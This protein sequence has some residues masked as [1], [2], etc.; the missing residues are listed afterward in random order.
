[1]RCS[2]LIHRNKYEFYPSPSFSICVSNPG[3]CSTF[4]QKIQ[5]EARIVCL[6]ML[7]QLSIF[8]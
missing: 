3:R 7:R 2:K 5:E 4:F 1:M 8:K 6:K